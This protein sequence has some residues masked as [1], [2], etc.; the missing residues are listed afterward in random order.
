MLILIVGAGAL[1]RELTRR[2]IADGHDV[3]VVDQDE[4]T[5]DAVY[6]NDGAVTVHG[7]GTDLRVLR[8]A[9]AERADVVV[10]TMRSDS[11]N[12]ACALLACSLGAAQIVARMQDPSYE[13]AYREAGTNHV[14]RG[15]RLMSDEIVAR[16]AHPELS[17]VMT[18][19]SDQTSVFSVVVSPDGWAEGRTVAE[20]AAHERF[21]DEC[22][23][24][25]LVSPD[26]TSSKIPRGPDRLA[27]GQTVLF[28]A[29]PDEIEGVVALIGA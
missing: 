9:G 6:A 5:C 13:E 8:D 29:R 16:I 18:L 27:E 20:L 2:L 28:I 4:E 12:V 10:T 17:E 21:P 3:I 14:V 19:H 11:D 25:G 26:G 1:G 22:L 24:V 15:T 7:D 23:V